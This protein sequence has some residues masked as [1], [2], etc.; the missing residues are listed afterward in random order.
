LRRLIVFALFNTRPDLGNDAGSSIG[1]TNRINVIARPARQKLNRMTQFELI[2]SG[3][4]STELS[5]NLAFK[6]STLGRF[7]R[8]VILARLKA[9]WLQI[10]HAFR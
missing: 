3:E 4:I 1:A 9:M 2:T 10:R 6:P 8:M 5:D 7:S